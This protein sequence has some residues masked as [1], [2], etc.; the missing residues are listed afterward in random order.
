MARSTDSKNPVV[1][2]SYRRPDLTRMVLSQIAAYK[3]TKLYLVH[4]GL[5]K[6]E[7]ES[8]WLATREI[9]NNVDFDGVVRIYS[10]INLG[11]RE[12]FYSALDFVFSIEQKAIILEDDTFPADPFFAFMD[13]M[14]ALYEHDQTIS[15]VSGHNF[16][17]LKNGYS[18][19]F[20]R[21]SYIWGW[22]TWGRVW[23]N[24]SQESRMMEVSDAEI[25]S[26]R[27]TYVSFLERFLFERMLKKLKD[28]ATWDV[29][30]SLYLRQNSFFSVVTTQNMIK[31]LGIGP[32][33]TNTQ[34]GLLGA[35]NK[36]GTFESLPH[37][38]QIRLN[39]A[40]EAKMWRVRFLKFLR[41]LLKGPQH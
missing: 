33:G 23:N 2:F 18:H 4:D 39:P 31:N 6:R 26:I 35:E 8:A 15:I 16:A 1:L 29:P 9:L 28:L 10:D 19:F 3:P 7:H 38:R 22:G 20:S 27:G 37:P 36:L 12:R 24:F 14:L 5:L 25:R 41:S 11:L 17:P 34:R 32:D 40:Y 30:F 21:A 13:E